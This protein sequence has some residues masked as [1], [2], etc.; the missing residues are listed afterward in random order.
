MPAAA[1]PSAELEEA[2]TV[3][4]YRIWA[5]LTGRATFAEWL[6]WFVTIEGDGADGVRKRGP[7]PFELYDFQGKRAERW[8]AGDSEIILKARQLGFSWLAA[9]FAYWTAAY[10]PSSHVAV[11]S[12]GEREMLK[13]MRKIRFIWRR[14]PEALKGG[15]VVAMKSVAFANE[16]MISGFPSTEDAG[17]GETNRLVIFDEF[18][19]HPYGEQNLGA[20]LPTIAAGGQ[21]IAMSTANAELGPSGHFHDRWQAAQRGEGRMLPVF[22]PWNARP[23]RDGGC[24]CPDEKHESKRAKECPKTAWL[25][26]QRA[27][28]A[29]EQAFRANYPERPEDAF[30]GRE[31]LVYP[32]FDAQRHVSHFPPVPWDETLERRYALDMGGGDPT[33]LVI[34]G[35]YRK[36][37]EGHSRVHIYALG[38]WQPA[39]SIETI[40]GS[41]ANW[42]VDGGWRIGEGDPANGDIVSESL[43]RAG[44]PCRRGYAARGQGI[45]IVQ[46]YL[47]R[48]WVTFDA[49]CTEFV[50]EFQ[51]YRWKPQTDP[52]S[53]EK[54][55]TKTP[56]DHHGDALDALRLLLVGIWRDEM[57]NEGAF[58]EV[59]SDVEL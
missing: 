33:A 47:E 50:R 43:R 7:I 49:G 51:S 46:Q 12:A 27:D 25:E 6:E 22:V 56:Q 17:I 48:G 9:A 1:A 59:F 21:L 44:F 16:S 34:A 36:P 37:N 30:Q 13:F 14:M 19:M 57:G 4:R 11:L 15:A 39:P 18:A 10:H 28:Y 45:A 42:T 8:E 41:L 29:S 23:E 35:T 20:V 54:Y 53:R 24:D 2:A 3:L 55:A 31:G 52:N 38:H 40:T 32:M 58:S 5:V 26:K